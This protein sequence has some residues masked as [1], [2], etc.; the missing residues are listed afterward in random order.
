MVI[1]NR[2]TSNISPRDPD[3]NIN[4]YNDNGEPNIH[5]II[6]PFIIYFLFFLRTIYYTIYLF[7]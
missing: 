2:S 7:L 5:D 6:L 4:N 3:K 1:L